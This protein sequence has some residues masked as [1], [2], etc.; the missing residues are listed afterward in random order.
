MFL[1]PKKPVSLS[2]DASSLGMGAIMLQNIHAIAYASNS[3]TESQ[4]NYA[5]IEKEMLAIAFGCKCLIH[6]YL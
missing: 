3:L 6:D 5:Q 2:V 1:D 4:Q